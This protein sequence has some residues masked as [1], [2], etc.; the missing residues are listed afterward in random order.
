MERKRSL[1]LYKKG[2]EEEEECED[3]R[4]SLRKRKRI[5][6]TLEDH[7]VEDEDGDEEYTDYDDG[8]DDD[9]EDVEDADN[10]DGDVEDNDDN[11]DDDDEEQEKDKG[12]LLVTCGTKEGVLDAKKLARGK[13]CIKCKGVLFTPPA[14][15]EF[16]GKGSTKKWKATILYENKPLQFWLEQGHLSTKGYRRRRNNTAKNK[17]LP[18]NYESDDLSGG[19]SDE[20]SAEGTEDVQDDDCL[21]SREEQLPETREEE[22]E[23][24]E[25]G[26]KGEAVDSGHPESYEEEDQLEEGE[27]GDEYAPPDA[28][29]PEDQS[30]IKESHRKLITSTPEKHAL[31]M[32]PKIVISRLKMGGGD[33][34]TI[35]VEHLHEDC[36]CLDVNSDMEEETEDS[37]ATT[38]GEQ[39]IAASTQTELLQV[40]DPA[41]TGGEERR[42]EKENEGESLQNKDTQDGRRVAKSETPACL[43]GSSSPGIVIKTEADVDLTDEEKT[44]KETETRS[45]GHPEASASE[46]SDA[47]SNAIPEQQLAQE[48]IL[49]P[50]AQLGAMKPETRGDA[51][52]ALL[53]PASRD[54]A[55]VKDDSLHSTCRA[56]DT[57]E[58]DTMGLDQLRREKIKMQLKVLKLQEEYYTL[59]LTKLGKK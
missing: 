47:T 52:V 19:E 8:D 30:L 36:R 39:S 50:A 22:T 29:N 7:Y 44:G 16:A 11:D 2:E 55:A 49:G 10:D 40:S 54:C 41:I 23:R 51:A 12:L 31:H 42:G 24:V 46:D 26:N 59:K 32:E 58:V 53:R 17:P 5:N 28:D 38:L 4:Q 14:F 21:P 6:Y 18:L 20:Q 1:Y 43:S 9:D 33:C 57:A 27:T 15:E 37:S 48:E 13:E 56:T 25:D 3:R 45:K 35:S 34:Q